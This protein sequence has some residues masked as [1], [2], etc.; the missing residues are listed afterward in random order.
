M[1][2][3]TIRRI[4]SIV[5]GA[6]TIADLIPTDDEMTMFKHANLLRWFRGDSGFKGGTWACRK[7]GVSLVPTKPARPI[8]SALA[9]YNNKQSVVWTEQAPLQSDAACIPTAGNFSL[10]IVGRAQ[11]GDNAALISNA[12]A[13]GSAAATYVWFN[14]VGN[15]ISASL[16]GSAVTG[17]AI[18]ADG[19]P[20][21]L[22]I[23]SYNATTRNLTLRMQRGKVVA[24]NTLPAG[25]IN[26]NA[27]LRVGGAIA[28]NGVDDF[29]VNDAG[30]ETA[31]VQVWSLALADADNAPLLTMLEQAFGARYGIPQP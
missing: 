28:A 18:S 19:N 3:T 26:G 14:S 11:T 24:S 5:P 16:A 10:V 6:A 27:V 31:D 20:P 22:I 8:V 12:G 4:G 30:A 25:T 21:R 29:G 13:Q 2:T 15:Q 1:S 23:M 7:S 9:A 17:G